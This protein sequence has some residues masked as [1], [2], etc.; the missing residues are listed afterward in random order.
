MS[1][2][3][4]SGPTSTG[5]TADWELFF[6][7]RALATLKARL[8]AEALLEL[9]RPQIDAS[10]ATLTEW[11]ESSEGRW[12]PSVTE[13]RVTGLSAAEFLAHFET[14]SHDQPRMLAAQ[15]EHFVL[16]PRGGDTMQ[17]VENLGPHISDLALHFTGEQDAVAE[18]SPDHPTRMVGHAV[19]PNGEVVAHLLHQ[20]RDTADGFEVLL[21]IYFPAA[22]PE[23]FIEAHRQ[24]LAVEFTNWFHDAG[25]ALGRESP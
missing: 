18:L 10:T 9:L 7:R 8:G 19:L 2:T 3:V 1:I 15:P 6:A 23:A 20:F 13:M 25:Q 5:T 4:A 16:R 22:A 12:Q 17:V 24:H 21:G 14:I 11:I